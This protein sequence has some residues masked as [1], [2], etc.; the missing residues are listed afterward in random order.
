M[1]NWTRLAQ[2]AAITTL[3]AI[4]CASCVSVKGAWYYQRGEGEGADGPLYLVIVNG[5]NKEI[6]VKD[7]LVNPI[8]E[9]DD[10]RWKCS[11]SQIVGA[12]ELMVVSLPI[13]VGSDCAVPVRAKLRTDEGWV[14]VNLAEALPSALPAGW[15]GCVYLPDQ[16]P[17]KK[18]REQVPPKPAAQMPCVVAYAH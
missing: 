5:S 17:R 16:R 12:G 7:L 14:D 4:V 11:G 10:A 18:D 2:V 15:R 9:T 8:W 13:E 1:S 3:A 6:V